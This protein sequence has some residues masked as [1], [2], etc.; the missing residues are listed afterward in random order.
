MLPEQSV[1]PPPPRALTS[2]GRGECFRSAMSVDSTVSEGMLPDQPGFSVLSRAPTNWHKIECSVLGVNFT[3]WTVWETLRSPFHLLLTECGRNGLGSK[4]QQF[5]YSGTS[6]FGQAGF[7][8]NHSDVI[9]SHRDHIYF[10]FSRLQVNKKY[11]NMSLRSTHWN[12]ME[13]VWPIHRTL[14]AW[15]TR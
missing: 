2:S 10:Y 13:A 7:W 11:M 3:N 15:V 4:D 6:I 1:S 9:S 8:Y 14:K 12:V 5:L